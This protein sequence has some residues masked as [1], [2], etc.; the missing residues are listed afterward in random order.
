M[1]QLEQ[2]IAV[3]RRR[4]AMWEQR[5]LAFEESLSASV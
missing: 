4:S 2:A 3:V 5:A 1:A